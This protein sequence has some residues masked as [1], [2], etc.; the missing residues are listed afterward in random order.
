MATSVGTMHC[1]LN[2][3]PDELLLQVIDYL[4]AEPPSFSRLTQEP[5]LNLT[6]SGDCPLKALSTVSKVWRNL[7]L[8]VLFKHVRLCDSLRN[9]STW[10]NHGAEAVLD[11]GV[12]WSMLPRRTTMWV[13]AKLSAS[14]DNDTRKCLELLEFPKPTDMRKGFPHSL[15]KI[16]CQKE[17]ESAIQYD[18]QSLGLYGARF[19]YHWLPAFQF[20]ISLFLCFVARCNLSLRIESLVVTT[21]ERSP[22]SSMVDASSGRDAKCRSILGECHDAWY[23]LLSA[24]SP[25]QIIVVAPPTSLGSL[26]SGLVEDGDAW[27]FSDMRLHLLELR[28]ARQSTHVCD[29]APQPFHLSGGQI[30]EPHAYPRPNASGLLQMRDWSHLALNEGSFLKAYST[31]EYHLKT[32]PS[33]LLWLLATLECEA[34]VPGGSTGQSPC[35]LTSFSYTAIFP[36]GD[37]LKCYLTVMRKAL[38]SIRSLRLQLAPDPSSEILEDTTRL[39]KADLND[40]WREVHNG[41]DLE[42]TQ[43]LGRNSPL[44]TFT[45]VE[46]GTE[47]LVDELDAVFSPLEQYGWQ[48]Q[49]DTWNRTS[50]RSDQQE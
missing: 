39:A 50:G 38:P 28:C 32:P 11:F 27:A 25:T 12:D 29:S 19:L 22:G 48:R 24:I 40:C 34:T 6:V 35:R 33:I 2:E 8:P 14:T 1:G 10:L 41:Y 45:C 17:D 18:F 13:Q 4:D 7:V 44:E 20:Q 15:G 9:A 49:G 30:K 16:Q 31:Y 23:R 3:L 5:N 47:A 37:H 42:S 21:N 36:F 26:I 46:Y 43:L